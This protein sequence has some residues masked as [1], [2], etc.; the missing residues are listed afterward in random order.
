MVLPAKIDIESLCLDF[1]DACHAKTSLK[2]LNWLGFSVPLFGKSVMRAVTLLRQLKPFKFG[3]RFGG[4]KDNQGHCNASERSQFCEH[5]A[6]EPA[7]TA[8]AA[9]VKKMIGL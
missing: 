2:L 7:L 8:Y 5:G 9:C 1:A 4:L 6:A 3:A